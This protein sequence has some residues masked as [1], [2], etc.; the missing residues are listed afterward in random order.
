[1]QS[2]LVFGYVGLIEGIVARIQEQLGEK[3]KVV[4]TG[5]DAE[6]IARET[7]AIDIVNL[8]LAIIGLKLIYHMNRT[9][10]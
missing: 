10:S 6:L 8:N 9:C 4:A 2:G 3:A 7:K 1:M 5:G